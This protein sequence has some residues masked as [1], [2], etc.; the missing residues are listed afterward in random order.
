MDTIKPFSED[1]SY[2]QNINY[3]QETDMSEF[4]LTGPGDY[5]YFLSEEILKAAQRGKKHVKLSDN[6]RL[7]LTDNIVEKAKIIQNKGMPSEAKNVLIKNDGTI[8]LGT[9]AGKPMNDAQF[10]RALEKNKVIQKAIKKAALGSSK[11]ITLTLIKKVG[12]VIP[13]IGMGIAI[14]DLLSRMRDNKSELNNI[15]YGEFYHKDKGWY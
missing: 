15:P 9:K 10:A 2:G 3:E 13:W 5:D 14:G 6:L 12:K 11:A 8:V 1:I 4:G 7:T